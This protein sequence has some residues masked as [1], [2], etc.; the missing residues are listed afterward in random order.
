MV[1]LEPRESIRQRVQASNVR[2][3]NGLIKQLRS[4]LG[5]IPFLGA[6]VSA[7]L[8]YRQWGK[9]LAGVAGERLNPTNRAAVEKAV[10]DE[11]LLQAAGLLSEAL[12]LE[13]FQQAIADEFSEDR[14]RDADLT[15]GLFGYL[16]LITAGPVIT[17]NF[18][19]VAEHVFARAGREF[20]ATVYGANPH[21]VIPA[22]Q[23]NRLVLWKIH[24]DHRDARTRVFSD[25]EYKK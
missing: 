25:E 10:A 2:A 13:D 20:E 8:K 11:N 5:V 6:G 15:S 9:F 24:G 4:P 16:P 1:N 17:T 19:R 21:E 7:P 18:D 23:Q 12:G 14:L 22:I 3:R